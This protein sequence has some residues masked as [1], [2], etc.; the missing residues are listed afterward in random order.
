MIRRSVILTTAAVVSAVGLAIVVALPA[1][2]DW[3][4]NRHQET[5]AYATGAEAKSARASV[6]RWLADEAE[7]V[8]Y[9]MRTTGGDRLLK[10]TLTDDRLPVACTTEPRPKAQE[11]PLEEDW[12]PKDARGKATARCGLYYAYMDGTTLYA[13]QHNDDWLRAGHAEPAR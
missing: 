6:P 5:N 11:V 3:Y 8:R 10:A 7:S 9:A 12:F 13:W 4:G 2:A 1:A